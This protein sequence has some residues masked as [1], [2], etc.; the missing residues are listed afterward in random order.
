MKAEPGNRIPVLRHRVSGEAMQVWARVLDDPNPI[1]VDREFVRSHGLGDNLI[2][3]GPANLAYL[4]N[5]LTAAFPEA[6]LE[7]IDVRFLGNVFAGETV[8]ASGVIE[9]IE[10]AGEH[11]RIVCAMSLEA[12][13]R[14]PVVA[15]RATV[16]L[17]NRKNQPV[18]VKGHLREWI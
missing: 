2:N 4:I 11:S 9:A 13:G 7:S 16:I 12:P 1:H 10:S 15:G 3:Q 18:I 8:E 17:P 14:G 5:A 6:F